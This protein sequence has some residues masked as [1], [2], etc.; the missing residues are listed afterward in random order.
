VCGEHATFISFSS[1]GSPLQRVF[2]LSYLSISQELLE[3]LG[4]PVLRAKH[5]AEGLCAQLEKEGFVHACLTPDSDV[6]L[7]GARHVIKILQPDRKV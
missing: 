1:P 5:E 4:L 7:Y 2:S 6:F 3:L